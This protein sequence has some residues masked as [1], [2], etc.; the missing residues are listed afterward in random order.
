MTLEV[1]ELLSKGAIVETQLTPDSF[2][3]QIFLVEKKDGGQ[4][5]VINLKALNQLMRVEHFKIE[6]LHLLPDLLQSGDWM[7]KM[8]LKDAY[9]QVL[10]NPSHQPLLSFQ[11][12]KKYYR[13]TC[14]PFCLSAA[15]RVLI[16]L[17]KPVVCFLCQ[18]GCCLIIYLDDL[19][20][21][22]QDR[23][24]LQQMV[25]LI[26][27]LFK[28]FGPDG[29]SQEIYSNTY[30]ESGVL[31]ILHQLPVHAIITSSREDKENKQDSHRLLAQQSVL[32]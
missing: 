4:R 16:K 21:L 10:I 28:S 15:P 12:E 22:H 17:L 9:L 6:G 26:I 7:V 8:G 3:S 30:L 20:I 24:R 18:V 31:G 27:Q 32:A 11:W 1:M 2:V 13:F 14:L 19:L 23:H 25:L 29:Q 5:L